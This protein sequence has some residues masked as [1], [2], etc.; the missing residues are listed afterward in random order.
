[1]KLALFFS[2]G[3]S[4][5]TWKDSGLLD[6]E[7]APYKRMLSHMESVSFVTYGNDSE[8]LFLQEED[9]FKVLSNRWGLPKDLYSIVS[10]L[11]YGVEL[12]SAAIYKTN[13]IS[14]WWT[15]GL[16]KFLY[17][18]PLVVRC[19]YLLSMD[20][21]QKWKKYSWLRVS[22]ISLLEN[23]AFICADAIIVTTPEMKMEVMRR[24]GL[25]P[26]KI[27]VIPNSVDTDLFR[28]LPEIKTIPGRLGFVGRFNNQK[29]LPLLLEAVSD[30]EEISLIFIGGGEKRPELESRASALGIHI[31][32]YANVPNR[33]IPELLNTCQA[34]VLPSRWEGMP[35]A[36]IE[37]MA[38]GLPVI[39]TNVSGIRDIIEHDRTGY[40]CEPTIDGLRSAIKIILNDSQ[41]RKRLGET[42][43]EYVVRNFSIEKTVFKELELLF[44]M[45]KR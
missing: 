9:G 8:G 36:L 40:L 14:G 31:K 3:I 30:I 2:R 23:L 25:P 18:K 42:A 37:A 26:E 43:R 21:E 13:Q 7:L 38:C 19:G 6:R 33:D 28:P 17:G 24:Y 41:L 35:K 10:P 12:R 44:S 5:A 45:E 32:F 34:F 20:Q 11:L 4:L 27:N 22:L 1:M 15:A 39:G 16:A 29:N